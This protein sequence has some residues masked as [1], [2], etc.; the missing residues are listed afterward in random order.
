MPPIRR[1]GVPLAIAFWTTTVLGS[2][3]YNPRSI[4][5]TPPLSPSPLVPQDDRTKFLTEADQRALEVGKK[6]LAVQAALQSPCETSAMDAIKDLGHDSRYY[7]LTRG[8]IHQHLRMAESYRDTQKYRETEEYQ[9]Q[10]D[11]RIQCL[12]KMIRALDLE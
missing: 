1:L 7:V 8:W 12:Q 10:V 2:L 3:F 9:K 6:V 11:K 4:P 5:A